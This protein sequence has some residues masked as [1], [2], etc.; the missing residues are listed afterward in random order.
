MKVL[1]RKFMVYRAWR[2]LGTDAT[3]ADIAAEAGCSQVYARATLAKMRLPY[4]HE[5][6]VTGHR[7]LGDRA[8]LDTYFNSRFLS[9]RKAVRFGEFN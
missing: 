2:K 7:N 4:S 3:S 5:Y 8:P 1:A 9:D 6:N